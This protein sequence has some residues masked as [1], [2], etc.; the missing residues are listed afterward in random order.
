MVKKIKELMGNLPEGRVSRL[1]LGALTIMALLI[2]CLFLFVG[3]AT[4][5]MLVPGFY[6][7]QF[8][9]TLLIYMYVIVTVAV[10]IMIISIGYS[11]WRR[12]WT[13]KVKCGVPV[14][15]IVVGVLA[16][17]V[18]TMLTTF[19][20]A[21]TNAMTIGGK[22]YEDTLWLRLSDMF[23]NTTL[24]LLVVAVLLMVVRRKGDNV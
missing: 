17:L 2:F 12:G 20:L 22:P 11:A 9:D 10:V 4:P 14:T 7:P 8:T 5:S 16:L 23:I 24:V 6:E 1:V 3:F 19:M 18:I 21:D 15:A 13:I